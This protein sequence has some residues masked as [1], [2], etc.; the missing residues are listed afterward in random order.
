MTGR[1]PRGAL[2]GRGVHT[3]RLLGQVLADQLSI[4]WAHK[5]DGYIGVEGLD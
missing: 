4:G 3:A 2:L 5:P 1:A